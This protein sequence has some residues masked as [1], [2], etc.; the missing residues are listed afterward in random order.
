MV[1]FYSHHKMHTDQIEITW[2]KVQQ[3]N[4]IIKTRKKTKEIVPFMV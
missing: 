1:V 3:I 4:I 2:V